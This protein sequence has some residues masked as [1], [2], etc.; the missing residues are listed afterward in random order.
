MSLMGFD[1]VYT[2]HHKESYARH[3]QIVVSDSNVNLTRSSGEDD[4]TT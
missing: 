3:S 1:E 4:R 2:V